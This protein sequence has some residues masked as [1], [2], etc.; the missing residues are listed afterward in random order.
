MKTPI[1]ITD[2]PDGH[3]AQIIKI[4]EN[5][6]KRIREL[7]TQNNI[8]VINTHVHGW[9]HYNSVLK[10]MRINIFKIAKDKRGAYTTIFHE[11]GHAIDDILNRVSYDPSF[12]KALESD[13]EN[14]KRIIGIQIRS[15]DDTEIYGAIE[16]LL[17]KDYSGK[18]T[19][20]II[21]GITHCKCGN[22]HPKDYWRNDNNRLGAE[23]FA[24]F[25]EAT[26]RN[27]EKKL[28]NL[29]AIFP[30]GYKMFLE[31]IGG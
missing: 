15:H 24:H 8:L 7:L 23:A 21:S 4:I 29:A 11:A 30:N 18:S 17:K 20:D 3:G 13:F 26:A 2:L 6:P 9:A 31:M 16:Q 1:S 19:L 12:R 27:D 28:Q 10:A 22:G 14:F 5:A 25:F